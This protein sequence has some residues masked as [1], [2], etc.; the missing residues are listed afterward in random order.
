[1]RDEINFEQDAGILLNV[2][3]SE[4]PDVGVLT[5]HDDGRITSLSK[6]CQELMQLPASAAV[7]GSVDIIGQSPCRSFL[8]LYEQCKSSLD[9]QCVEEDLKLMRGGMPY[10][11]NLSL[12]RCPQGCGPLSDYLLIVRDITPSRRELEKA[13]QSQSFFEAALRAIPDAA[14][15]ADTEGCIAQVSSGAERL[16]GYSQEELLGR[17]AKLLVGEPQMDTVSTVQAEECAVPR[18]QIG[19]SL[20]KHGSRLTTEMITDAIEDMGGHVL[21]T[22]TVLRDISTQIT[23]QNDLLQQTLLLDSI[24]RQVPFA[25]GVIGTDRQIIQMSDSALALFR[26]Q[27]DQMANHSIRMIY[28]TQEEFER[29]GEMMYRIRPGEPVVADLV[30]AQ[31]RQFYG[32]VQVAPLFDVEETIR[33][34]LLAIED[35]TEQLAYGE[36][37]RRYE[38]IVS[39]SS[40]ALIFI[41][42]RHIYCAANQAYL[43]LWQKSREEIIGAHISEIVGE[44]FYLRYS[45]PALQRCFKGESVFIDPVEATYPAGRRFVDVRHTPYRNNQGQIT[46]VLITLRDVSHH[47]LAELAMQESQER[48]RLAGDF[49]EFAVW[50]LDVETRTPVDDL[51]LRRMLGYSVAD[52]FDSLDAWLSVVLDPDNQPLVEWFEQILTNPDIDL[53]ERIECRVQKKSGEMVHVENLIEGRLRDGKRRLVGITRNITSLVQEREEL[54]KY[55]RMTLAVRDGLALIDR[56][57]IFRAVNGFY[58]KHY[59]RAMDA[60]VGETVTTLLGEQFYQREFKPMLDRCFAGEEPQIECWRNYPLT[61]RRRVEISFAPYHDES[62]RISRVLVTT[63]DITDSYLSQLALRESEEKFRAIFDYVPIGVVILAIEDGSILDANPASLTMHGYEKE[64]YLSLKPWEVVVEITPRNFAAEWGRVTERRRSRFESEHWRKDGSTLHVLVD[65]SRV[66]INEREVIVSTLTDITH[67]KQL[68]LKLREQ[69][70]QYRLLVESSNAILFSADPKTFRFNFVSQEAVH[71]LG[72]PVTAWANEKDFWLNHLH[73]EDRQWAPEYCLSM[74]GQQKDHEFDYRM[75]AAD[76]RVVWLHDVTSVIVA[77]GKVVSLVGVM[78][79]ITAGK[80]A[81]AER[82]RL[83]EMIQQS[84]DAILLTDTDFKVA[85]INKA[86]TELYGYDIDD[87]RGRCPEILD[88]EADAEH[89]NPQIYSDLQAGRQVSRELLNLR[90]DGSHFYCQHTINPLRN[91]Q[92]DIIAYMSSQRDVSMRKNA[93]RA[94]IES[95]EKYRQIV[96]TAHEGI[97]VVDGQAMTTFVNPRLA[98]ML[99]YTD[100]EMSRRTLFDF[101]DPTNDSMARRFWKRLLRDGNA[102]VDLLFRRKDGSDLWSHVS[103]RLMQ[104]KQGEPVSVMT[105]LTDITEQRQLTDALVRSQKMEAVGQLTGGIAHDFNN[106][107]GSILGFAELAQM[108]F[109]DDNAKLHEYLVQIETAGGRARDLI[110]QLLVFSR[111]EN[112]RSAAAVPLTPLIKEV[113]KMLV[114]MLPGAIEIRTELPVDMISAKVDPLHVQQ[115]L[116]N[117]CINARDM[118]SK[119]GLITVKLTKRDVAWGQCTICG[120]PVSGEWVS[121]QVIDTGPGIDES[122]RDDIFQP[123]I[124]SKE[125][126]EGSGMGLAVV[127]GIVNSYNGHVLVESSPGKG[128]SFEILLPEAIEEPEEA[129]AET[130]ADNS[131]VRLDGFMILTVDDETQFRSYCNELLNDAGAEVVSCYS[132]IQALG[133]YAR[134]GVEFDLIITDQS[135][136]GMSGTEMV[137]ALRK[138]GCHTPVIL[139]SGYGQEVELETMQRLG[140]EELLPKPASRGELMSAIRRVLT[141]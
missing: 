111:G 136:P 114:P 101:L 11:L 2:L 41:D 38:Q 109:G 95:E 34:Y 83:S 121:I 3:L 115:M 76:G 69:Q 46:G 113:M 31:G 37:L 124:T 85:Y 105:L 94:L 72:Y 140:I 108:R 18:F 93:E 57:H 22:I 25:L 71:L 139:C 42:D 6:R 44:E 10:W 129:V 43:D 134:D 4:L 135:I 84:T 92:G 62:G 100:D 29:V 128:A 89:I 59:G 5:W 36:E 110:R 132:G 66:Q 77:D 47:H 17:S 75:I 78:V 7:G 102:T 103:T 130:A 48:F 45:Q 23:M 80:E 99:G 74:I 12:R 97:W 90:K 133:R 50:E 98:E 106:I 35:V 20:T 39:A 119:S 16:F 125:V 26:Y 137:Q 40:D 120:E 32:H 60:I 104:A 63:H 19:E 64:E 138:L 122:L 27:Q 73:P 127:R 87:L 28:S 96:E 65:A 81:E 1:M 21:G 79:D 118:I 54:R 68:E 67:L 55:E 141:L 86:F 112:T 82:W 30:D 56:Q 131:R 33:G 70:G 13:Q 116:M 24:F 9:Q 8:A 51:M 88:A 14:I 52:A 58:V 61:G 117:L 91:D 49:A 107:L 15:V 123:F 126:G 53:S